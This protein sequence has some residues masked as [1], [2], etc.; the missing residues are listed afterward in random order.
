MNT[1]KPFSPQ[2][3]AERWDCSAEKIRIMCHRG[4]LSW[5]PFGKSMRIPAAEVE[6]FECQTTPLRGTVEN[7]PS[8]GESRAESIRFASRLVRQTGS[9]TRMAPPLPS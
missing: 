8:H 1:A 7:S 6:R 2:T 5:F 4:D 3:L 9:L